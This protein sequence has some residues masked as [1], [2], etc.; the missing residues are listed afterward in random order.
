MPKTCRTDTFMSGKPAG[1]ETLLMAAVVINPPRSRAFPET[2][3]VEWLRMR[4]NVNLA[5]STGRQKPAAQ[6]KFRCL[7]IEIGCVSGFW[8]AAL[9][10][11]PHFFRLGHLARLKTGGRRH[12]RLL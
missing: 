7:I 1:S 12:F 8:R 5:E 9:R 4:A 11:T 6:S 2:R 3:S 10:I